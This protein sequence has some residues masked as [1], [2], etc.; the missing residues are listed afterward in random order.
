MLTYAFH[1]SIQGIILISRVFTNL[2]S[3]FFMLIGGMSI[4]SVPKPN[5]GEQ[6]FPR[7]V[8]NDTYAECRDGVCACRAGSVQENNQCCKYIPTLLNKYVGIN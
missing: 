7:D 6:C 4:I 8:C 3:V 5:L 1:V 2:Y